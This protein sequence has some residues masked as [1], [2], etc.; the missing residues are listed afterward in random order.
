MKGFPLQEREAAE[1]AR[2]NFETEASRLSDHLQH[3]HPAEPIGAAQS[4]PLQDLEAICAE[5]YGRWDKDMRSGKLLQALCG[6]LPRYRSDVDRVRAALEK[7]G[8][9]EILERQL[10]SLLAEERS[11]HVIIANLQARAVKHGETP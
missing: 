5:I 6:T 1:A 8:S 4:T 2:D 11:L 9:I 7:T 10:Q 3:D